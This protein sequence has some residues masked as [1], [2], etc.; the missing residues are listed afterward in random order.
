MLPTPTRWK[1]KG[2]AAAGGHLE[3]A[4]PQPPGPRDQAARN[5]AAGCGHQGVPR[6]RR[7]ERGGGVSVRNKVKERG[8]PD[9]GGGNWRG[10][11]CFGSYLPCLICRMPV[12]W[13]A[14][15]W[16]SGGRCA[17]CGVIWRGGSS[18]I[19]LRLRGILSPLEESR[20]E[21]LTVSRVHA[22]YLYKPV[23]LRL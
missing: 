6:L 18:R 17:G 5:G 2:P 8:D 10:A 13:L 3:A 21:E 22:V 12:V 23:C 7:R 9:R 20:T 1:R 16:E 11:E 14:E 19:L 15:G 4:H